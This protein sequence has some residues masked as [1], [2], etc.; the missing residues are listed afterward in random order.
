MEKWLS[1]RIHSESVC[2]K[3]EKIT[4]QMAHIS[5]N[6]TSVD[7]FELQVYF[8]H[9]LKIARLASISSLR[10]FGANLLRSNSSPHLLHQ[11]V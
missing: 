9:S 3:V 1:P 10:E 4:N 5:P 7:E 6:Y 11:R 8:M 2:S